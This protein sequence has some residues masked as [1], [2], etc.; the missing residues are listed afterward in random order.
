MEDFKKIIANKISNAVNLNE[1]EIYGYIEVPPNKEMG[2]YAFPCFKLARELKK[3]PNMIAE[4]LKE[5]IS[6]DDVVSKVEIAGGY[7]NFFINPEVIVKEVLNNINQMQDR[8]GS[9]DEGNGKN[10]VID[11]SSPNIAKPFHIGHLRTTIIGQALY[12][13]YEYMGYNSIGINHLGDYGTQFGKLIEG[14]KRWGTEYDIENNPIDNLMKIY[15]R[16]NELCKEDETVLEACRENFR[17]LEQGDEYCHNLW[18]KFRDVSL[19]E[20]Q[21]IY[22][23]LN[24]KF[25]HITGESFYTDK[26]ADAVKVLDDQNLIVESEGARVIDLD[27]DG[28]NV[29]IVE[30][31]NGSS[32]Y[33]TRDLATIRYRAS[34]FD[35]DKALYVVA[36]EQAQYFKQLFR[37]AQFLDIPEKCK[38]GLY[39][40]QY[41]MTRLTTGKMSTREGTVVKVEDLLN[42]S[43]KRVLDV[44]NEKDP[45]MENKEL[46]AKRIGIGAVIFNNLATTIIKDQ[47]FD[48]DTALNFNGET[49]PYIQYVYVRTKSVLEKAGYVP[50]YKEDYAKNLL[51]KAS[52]NVITT[53][54]NFKDTLNTVIE[55]S[56][57]SFLARYLITLGQAYSNFY[58]E[59]KIICDDKEL[60]DARIYLTKC[61]G[62]VLKQGSKLLGIEMPDRM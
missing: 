45:E 57:P 29:F 1:E 59:N 56:D 26:M 53:L 7:L 13:I 4:E 38:K 28:K 34:E 10:V 18:V 31:T 35:F 60:Q 12:N 16:I 44:I 41:G 25:D 54:Y 27:G 33:G 9:S 23:L 58:N 19:Q 48:W 50:E 3:A 36:Y 43:I 62:T 32:I 30:K 39:H 14:Y 47:V 61:V 52:I 11:Y 20:F 17:L 6:E 37:V 22:D 5:K 51:D 46:E 40:V 15:V 21:K 24:V 8:Y 42:E 2:D 55:K 49:G